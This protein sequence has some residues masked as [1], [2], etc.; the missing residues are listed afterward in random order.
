MTRI[1]CVDPKSLHYKHLIAEYR[2]LPRI[3][4]L[5]Q[6]IQNKGLGP[7]DL[8]LPL[9]YRLGTGHV[10]FFYNKLGWLKRRQKLLT[11]EIKRRGYKLS[12]DSSTL[13]NGLRKD[14]FGDWKPTYI[15]RIRNIKRIN[16]RLKEMGVQRNPARTT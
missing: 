16:Q 14:W 13:G 3:F 5:V 8:D 4:T 6:A 7:S 2:E 15:D 12:Y 10:R 11:K 9:T 1:N